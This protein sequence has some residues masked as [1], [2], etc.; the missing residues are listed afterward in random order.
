MSDI[1]EL[2]DN[3][4]IEETC[5]RCAIMAAEN[6]HAGRKQVQQKPIF[7]LTTKPSLHQ[8]SQDL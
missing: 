1:F 6:A 8:S 4:W 2:F 5:L 3:V 7:F